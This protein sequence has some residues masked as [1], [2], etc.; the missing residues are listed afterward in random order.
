MTVW[1]I[2]VHD[3]VNFKNCPHNIFGVT[4]KWKKQVSRMTPGDVI[5]FLTSKDFGLNS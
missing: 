4:S 1:I 3:G 2:R 5:W